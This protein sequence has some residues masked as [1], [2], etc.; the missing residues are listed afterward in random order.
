MFSV[1]WKK[2]IEYGTLV[3]NLSKFNQGILLLS[4]GQAG[5]EVKWRLL[6]SGRMSEE[7]EEVKNSLKLS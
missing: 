3:K 1:G 2:A 6:L 4:A 7:E 5:E